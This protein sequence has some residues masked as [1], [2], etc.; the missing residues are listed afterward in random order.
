M[1]RQHNVTVDES[2]LKVTSLLN[3]L[4]EHA[5]IDDGAT[6]DD[7]TLGA[8]GYKSVVTRLA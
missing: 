8:L 7:Q 2:A 6:S 1:A 5:V 3:R 4:D